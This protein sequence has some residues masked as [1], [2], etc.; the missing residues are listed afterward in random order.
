MTRGF[1]FSVAFSLFPLGIAPVV[2]AEEAEAVAVEYLIGLGAAPGDPELHARQRALEFAAAFANQGYHLRDG[3]W[4][5]V[6]QPK[7]PRL[8]SLQLF[9]GNEY[10]FSAG[11]AGTGGSLDLKVY[12]QSGRVLE[13][14]KYRREGSSAIGVE[15]D[16]TGTYYLE[17]VLTEGEATPFCLVYSFK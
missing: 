17:V 8:L 1:I 6:L 10:W 13:A 3:Y 16:T 7:Q 11:I 4:M 2:A 5:E 15:P 14:Q 9:A 12:D